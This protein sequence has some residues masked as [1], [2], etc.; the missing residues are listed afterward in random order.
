MKDRKGKRKTG[1]REIYDGKEHHGKKKG[2]AKDRNTEKGISIGRLQS[3]LARP[4]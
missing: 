3:S 1:E 4:F 2:M